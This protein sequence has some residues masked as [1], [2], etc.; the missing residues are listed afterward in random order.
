[1]QQAAPGLQ[2][3]QP[4]AGEAAQPVPTATDKAAK[5]TAAAAASS[6]AAAAQQPTAAEPESEDAAIA[7][8]R[9]NR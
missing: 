3:Q 5:V 9:G 4:S 6:P 2:T 1:M 8:Q 7:A